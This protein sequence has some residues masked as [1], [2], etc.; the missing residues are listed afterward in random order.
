M[1]AAHVAA[2]SRRWEARG[3]EVDGALNDERVCLAATGAIDR[4]R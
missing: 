2:N 4:R 1:L 3:V